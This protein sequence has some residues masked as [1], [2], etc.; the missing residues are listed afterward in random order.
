MNI[1]T[2]IAGLTAGAIALSTNAA[3]AIYTNVDDQAAG[4]LAGDTSPI[5]V[6]VSSVIANISTVFGATI[7]VILLIFGLRKVYGMITKS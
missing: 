3:A 4:V 7:L 5:L 1:M 2:K 6:D